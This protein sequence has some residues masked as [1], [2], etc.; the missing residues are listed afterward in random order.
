MFLFLSPCLYS[1]LAPLENNSHVCFT[2]SSLCV[3]PGSKT[4]VTGCGPVLECHIDTLLKSYTL[5][6]ALNLL[7]YRLVVKQRCDATHLVVCVRQ[8]HCLRA[9]SWIVM[10]SED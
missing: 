7:Q 2:R 10:Y 8:I 4:T 1:T 3:L 5:S 9:V 6:Q